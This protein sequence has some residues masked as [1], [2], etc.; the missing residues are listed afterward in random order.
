PPA[1]R[2]RMTVTSGFY[3]RS[4]CHDLGV[5]CGSLGI[6]SSLIRTRQGD[7]ALG[8]ANVLEYA[9]LEKGPDVWEPQVERLLSSFMEREGWGEV[10]EEHEWWEEGLM[11]IPW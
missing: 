11:M 2:L 7:Y 10:F 6:M 8:G 9:D 1:A 4:L 5:A 3:V